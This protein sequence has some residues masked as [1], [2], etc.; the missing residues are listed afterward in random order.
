MKNVLYIGNYLKNRKVNPSYM[1]SLGDALESEGYQVRFTSSKQNKLLRLLDMIGKTI[2]S[3]KWVDYVLIDT[4][5]TS[6][7]YYAYVVSQICRGLS[8]KYIPILHGGNLPNRLEKSPRLSRH[9]FKNAHINVAPSMYLLKSFGN[10]GYNDLVYI[11]NAISIEDYEYHKRDQND[12]IRLLWVRA[13]RTIYNPEL[14]V[15]VLRI[16]LDE[17]HKASLCMIGPDVDGSLA[18]V[19][20]LATDLKVPVDFKGKMTKAEWGKESMNHNVFINTT[21]FDNTPLSV[22]EA[23]AL[24][25]VVISTDVGGLPF[26]V[27]NGKDGVLVPPDDAN[28]MA[29]K[30]ITLHGNTKIVHEMTENARKKAEHFDWAIV[31][32]KW[33]SILS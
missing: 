5:S 4:Y 19:K 3:R 28:A 25:L 30:I 15:K 8:I 21:N 23:M 26:L 14:A 11:P 17:G 10:K 20:S 29:D 32:G 33:K 9:I 27:D 31:I 7:F 16:L 24:G 18:K 1:F 22:I 12:T 2:A 6:N 13:F